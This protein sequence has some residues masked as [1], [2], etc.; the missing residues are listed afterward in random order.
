MT[1]SAKIAI[2][3]PPDDLAAA[4]A[5]ARALGRSRSCAGTSR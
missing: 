4:D 5:L 3:I 2:T 1:K